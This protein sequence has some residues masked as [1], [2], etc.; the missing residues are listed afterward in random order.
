MPLPRLKNRSSS[1]SLRLKGLGRPRSRASWGDSSSREASKPSI[2]MSSKATSK[3]ELK[4]HLAAQTETQQVITIEAQTENLYSHTVGL[5]TEYIRTS[6]NITRQYEK[7]PTRFIIVEQQSQQQPKEQGRNIEGT[8]NNDNYLHANN[9]NAPPP[10]LNRYPVRKFAGIYSG[11]N[12]VRK[13]KLEP[14]DVRY[15]MPFHNIFLSGS[16]ASG[17]GYAAVPKKSM[18]GSLRNVVMVPTLASM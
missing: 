9:G 16:K 18:E 17:S 3:S 10:S 15:V 7:K 6:N 4:Q 1:K 11:T 14:Y 12:P 8:T 2:R 13:N 5:Q